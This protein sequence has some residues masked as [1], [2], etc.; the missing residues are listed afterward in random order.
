[1]SWKNSKK[2]TDLNYKQLSKL[3]KKY[4][5]SFFILDTIKFRKNFQKFIKTF[6]SHYPKV[7]VGYSYKTNY[8]PK[9]CQIVNE[10]GGYAEIA[11]EME[12]IAA[13]KIGVPIDKIIYNGPSKS[14]KSFIEAAKKGAIINIDNLSE[15]PFLKIA[16]RTNIKNKIRVV[17]RI[18]FEIGKQV[19]RFGI[20][21]KADD[22]KIIISEI[23]KLS[24]VD[25]VGLHC[26]F[27]YRDLKSFKTRAEKLSSLINVIFP[28]ELPDIINIGGGYCSE[29]TPPELFK[30]K[31]K[32]SDYA[33][34]VGNILSKKFSKKK[35]WPALFLEPGTALV[36][37]C[38][39]F[40][41]Q[42]KSLKK[43]RG[44]GFATVGGSVLDISPNSRLSKLPAQ[45]VFDPK[46][47]R[48]N[49]HSAYNIVGYTCIE[50]DYLTL[51]LKAPLSEG[52]FIVYSNVGSYSVVMRPPFISPSNPILSYEG[53][54]R[55]FKLIKQRQ[56]NEDVFKLFKY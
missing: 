2:I 50:N 27:P 35:K 44:V 16:Q 53:K 54:N 49:L 13:K 24:N 12:Y 5:H 15:I 6:K 30:S 25:L 22:L 23:D 43:V 4:G 8:T 32:Y 17:L 9:L 20:D 1:M 21:P 56:S 52:D 33:K 11:S 37:N 46:I 45:P 42:V 28:K 26:H 3:S 41:T 38:Q 47:K 31:L 40:C 14:K 18:N 39:I 51:N 55:P 48:K 34:V 36:S 19:S 29:D 7:C 10:E